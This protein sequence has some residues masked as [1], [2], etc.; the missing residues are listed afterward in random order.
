[1]GWGRL[2][3]WPLRVNPLETG[4]VS[5]EPE[6]RL[7]SSPQVIGGQGG[8]VGVALEEVLD[9]VFLPPTARAETARTIN[10]KPLTGS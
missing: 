10:P 5:E 1:M 6:R 2:R 8:R 4:P 3:G 9:G 7:G